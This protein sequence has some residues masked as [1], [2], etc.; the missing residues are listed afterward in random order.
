M[1]QFIAALP[2]GQILKSEHEVYI[3]APTPLA[4]TVPL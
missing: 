3:S 2:I 1:Q 4:D